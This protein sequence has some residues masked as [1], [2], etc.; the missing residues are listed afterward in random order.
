MQGH[1]AKLTIVGLSLVMSAAPVRVRVVQNAFD[2]SAA[3]AK[4]ST[5]RPCKVKVALQVSLN[6]A[7]A[8]SN[9]PCDCT[10]C[11]CQADP[12]FTTCQ[13]PGFKCVCAASEALAEASRKAEARKKVA[14]TPTS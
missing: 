2:V 12:L 7:A 13:T 6:D 5:G 11:M 4:P 9:P 3:L 14:R 10:C 1:W 8:Q